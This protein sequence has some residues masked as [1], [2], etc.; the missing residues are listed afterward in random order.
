VPSQ[1]PA[2]QLPTTP[3]ILKGLVSSSRTHETPPRI[4]FPSF[5]PR[6]IVR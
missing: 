2:P 6:K 5:S 4:Q 3:D 1:P